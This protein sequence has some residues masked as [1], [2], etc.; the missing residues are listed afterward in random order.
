MPVSINSFVAH[1]GSF[2]VLEKSTAEKKSFK[3]QRVL[4]GGKVFKWNRAVCVLH[5]FSYLTAM[6]LWLSLGRHKSFSPFFLLF[7]QCAHK[8]THIHA[9]THCPLLKVNPAAMFLETFKTFKCSRERG[10]WLRFCGN[11]N[12][13]FTALSFKESHWNIAVGIC[14]W[15]KEAGETEKSSIMMTAKERLHMYSTVNNCIV[16]RDRASE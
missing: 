4:N 12:N 16:I 13:S 8:N 6:F 14:E 2:S 3:V 11:K 1:E 15:K 7:A 10:E 5:S 9:Y